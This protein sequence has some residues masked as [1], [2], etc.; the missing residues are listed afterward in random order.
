MD[1]Q[2]HAGYVSH[3]DIIHKC[4]ET[5]YEMFPNMPFQW[6][7][8][9]IYD[10]TNR[11]GFLIKQE[12]IEDQLFQTMKPQSKTSAKGLSIAL[13][14]TTSVVYYGDGDEEESLLKHGFSK[15]RCSDLKQI[16]V[17]LALTKDGIPISHEVF[18]GNTND[19]TCFKETIHKFSR[20]YTEP[21]VTPWRS[22]VTL[23]GSLAM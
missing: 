22:C 19:Q 5:Y 2:H 14:D 20:K 7:V 9:N 17:G 21:N 18:S 6:Y 3:Q 13:F 15:A 11:K 4:F 12:E 8:Q 23:Q 10:S 16:V 1:K